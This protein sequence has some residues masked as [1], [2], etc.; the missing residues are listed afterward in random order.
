MRINETNMPPIS[1]D[2]LPKR[3][4]EVLGT[5]DDMVTR[6]FSLPALPSFKLPAPERAIERP[7]ILYA[8]PK[9]VV[10]SSCQRVSPLPSSQNHKDNHGMAKARQRQR[11]QA[12]GKNQAEI[13]NVYDLPPVSRV[14]NAFG[15]QVFVTRTGT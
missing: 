10:L 8:T 9:S 2:K 7:E 11:S 3:S 14:E 13:S 12:S 6:G 15:R 1:H 4:E 5:N